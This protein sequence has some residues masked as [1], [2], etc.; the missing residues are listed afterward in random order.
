MSH[1]KSEISLGR[2]LPQDGILA[3]TQIGYLLLTGCSN[4]CYTEVS[5]TEK[6]D[7]LKIQP[8]NSLKYRF[9]KLMNSCFGLGMN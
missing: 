3:P 7:H 8:I 1:Q 6:N 9:Q 4:L 2:K 5:I